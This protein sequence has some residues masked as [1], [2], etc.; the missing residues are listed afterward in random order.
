M[1]IEQFLLNLTAR[2]SDAKLSQIEVTDQ[3]MA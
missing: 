1:P 2:L 3:S